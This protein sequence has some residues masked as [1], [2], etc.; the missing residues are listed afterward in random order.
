MK[1]IDLHFQKC[2]KHSYDY[3]TQLLLQ[4]GKNVVARIGKKY[5]FEGSY[6]WAFFLIQPQNAEKLTKTMKNSLLENDIFQVLVTKG[7]I[8]GDSGGIF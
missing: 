6:L 5:Q 8:S 3:Y 1:D 2:Y 4:I 7:K